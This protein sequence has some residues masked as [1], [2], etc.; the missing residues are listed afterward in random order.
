MMGIRNTATSS[1]YE[2]TDPSSMQLH[3]HGEG[4]DLL[5]DEEVDHRSVVGN[6]NLQASSLM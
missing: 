3:D 1:V 5:E 2:L 6:P 4:C